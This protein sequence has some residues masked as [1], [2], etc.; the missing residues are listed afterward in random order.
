MPN[1]SLR[2]LPLKEYA[3]VDNNDP[4]RFY[5]WPFVGPLYRRRVELC[6][7][8]CKGGGRVLE[9]GFGSGLAFINL[10]SRYEEVHGLDLTASIADVGALFKKHKIETFLRNG[11]V[12]EMPYP[13]GFFDTVLCIS[14]LEHLKPY[15]L[16]KA[17]SEIRR[18]LKR[19]GQVVYGVP[20]NNA[21]MKICF[22]ILGYDI[23][24]HHFSSE[25]DVSGAARRALTEVKITALKGGVPFSG[26]VYE[27]GHFVNRNS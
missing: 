15:E 10:S 24:R 2:L 6:L 13:D 4:I 18:V 1:E 8:E 26:S 19:E 5:F 3:G 21:F 9:V 23:R 14:I 17:F 12:L 16:D 25:R 20:A 22:L 11:S 7:D 27:I